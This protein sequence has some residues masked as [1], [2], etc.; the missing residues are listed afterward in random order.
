MTIDHDACWEDTSIFYQ[1]DND[2]VPHEF[3]LKIGEFAIVVHRHTSY[4]KDMWLATCKPYLFIQR[5]LK[6][7]DIKEAQCQAV[8]IFDVIIRDSVKALEAYYRSRE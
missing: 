5:V 3:T 4:P 7:K 1:G 2:R 8:A 6:S